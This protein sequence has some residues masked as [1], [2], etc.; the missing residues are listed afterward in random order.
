MWKKR[1]RDLLPRE[2][3]LTQETK[4]SWP[5]FFT[6]VQI[7]AICVL[8][9]ASTIS[10]RR[11][12]SSRPREYRCRYTSTSGPWSKGLQKTLLS[13][14]CATSLLPGRCCRSHRVSSIDKT[15]PSHEIRGHIDT[16]K[17]FRRR[18]WKETWERL[19]CEGDVTLST[20]ADFTMRSLP[21][22]PV[23]CRKV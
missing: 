13:P 8:R 4:I 6:R 9:T 21:I 16:T 14:V 22:E 17:W 18:K 3:F 12:R 20:T 11:S 5:L 7:Y 23:R 1:W 10:A 2:R 15:R 19:L